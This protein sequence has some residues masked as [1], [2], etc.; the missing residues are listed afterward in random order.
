M[1][2]KITIPKVREG[3]REGLYGRVLSSYTSRGTAGTK[4]KFCHLLAV[5]AVPRV[6]AEMV[7]VPVKD[8][9]FIRSFPKR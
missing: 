8:K 9:S 1:H 7:F 2:E 3:E 6:N 4:P 5:A